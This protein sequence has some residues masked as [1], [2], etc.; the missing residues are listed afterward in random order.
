MERRQV[1]KGEANAGILDWNP[2]W[3]TKSKIVEN[4]ITNI[5]AHRYIK[6]ILFRLRKPAAAAAAVEE[7]TTTTVASTHLFHHQQKQPKHYRSFMWH[8][9]FSRIIKTRGRELYQI[10]YQKRGT[11]HNRIYGDFPFPFQYPPKHT[12]HTPKYI[13]NILCAGPT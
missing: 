11:Y 8:I 9:N 13:I 6:N 4:Y 2:V 5:I 3:N 10:W 12:A 1:V 7:E